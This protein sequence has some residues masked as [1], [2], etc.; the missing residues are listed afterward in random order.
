MAG[1]KI[2][3]AVNLHWIEEEKCSNYTLPCVYVTYIV[4]RSDPTYPNL[5]SYYIELLQFG[6]LST[7]MFMP[8]EN[9]CKTD[10]NLIQ[11]RD[12]PSHPPQT[13]DCNL[14]AF[15]T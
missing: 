9:H 10:I 7:S 13:S 2:F 3:F 4:C 1:H 6:P 8:S 12:T 14:K 11:D 5:G 15:C